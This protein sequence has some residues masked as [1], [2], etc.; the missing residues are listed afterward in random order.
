MK[1]I[2]PILILTCI[3]STAYSQNNVGIG[4]TTPHPSALLHVDG[5]DKGMLIPRLTTAQRNSIAA[6]ANGLMVYD[7]DLSCVFFYNSIS[8]AWVSLCAPVVPAGPTGPTGATGGTGIAGSTGPTGAVGATGSTG[9]T[10]ATG[11][12]GNTGAT[13]ATGT[14]GSTGPTGATGATGDTGATGAT[15]NTGATGITG[16]TGAMTTTAGGDLSGNYPN[17]TVVGLQGTAIANT[18]P[19]TDNV[20]LYNGTSWTPTDINNQFWRTTGNAGT[21]ASTSAYGTAANNNF[22]GPTSNTAFVM[23]S[24]AL[25]RARISATGNFGIGTANPDQLLELTGGGLQFNAT[26]GIGF[27]GETP[28]AATAP[29]LDGV[30]FYYDGNLFGAAF[31]GLVIEKTDPN[32]LPADGGIAFANR[33]SDNTRNIAM[34]IRGSGNI[35]IGTT[36][37]SRPLH[38]VSATQGAIRIVDGTQAAGRVLTSDATGVGTWQPTIINSAY[39]TLGAGVNIPYNT[40]GYIQTGTTVTLPPGKFSVTV[41]MLMSPNATFSPANSMFW[42]RTTFTDGAGILTASPDIIGSTLASGSLVGPSCYSVLSGSIIINNTSGANKTY[43]YAA[44][45]TTYTNTT[46]TLTLFGGTAWAENNIV[47]VQLN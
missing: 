22:I 39:G 46:Q 40:G 16:P 1:L 3:F 44:G 15:G 17:P 36:A 24:N 37:P 47:A 34:S 25:E 30:K 29:T 7:T 41:T 23:V 18:A 2:T 13:G 11:N 38:I 6:P 10:G 45:A 31:D 21:T 12:T 5:S 35:G 20:L 26:W 9:A 4:T 19:A 28:Q 42:L 43:Y 8:T 32:N 33:G 27:N 14:T